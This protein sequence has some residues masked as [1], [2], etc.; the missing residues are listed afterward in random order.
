M[1][2]IEAIVGI[3]VAG[4]IGAIGGGTIGLSLMGQ[5]ILTS[6]IY[7]GT[8][9]SRS[10]ASK[11]ES[12]TNSPTYQFNTLQTQT[13]NQLPIP[14]I[15][16][17]NKIAGNR[18]WQQYRDNNT[19]IDRIVAFGEGPIEDIED[20]RLNDIPLSE[21]QGVDFRLYYGTN[22]Q[23]T[24]P[25][26]GSSLNDRISTV[27]SLKNIAY[28][29]LSVKA[30][31]KIRGDYNLTTVVK[32][33]KVRVYSSENSYETK[34]SNNP[35][36][37]LLDFL[38][39]YNGCGIGLSATGARDDYKIKEFIDINSFI[40]AANICDETVEDA[41]RFCFN[42]IIDSQSQRQEILEEFKK[43]CR[44]A[45]TIKGKRL[46]L[47]ID[48]NSAPCKT[49]FAKDII[50]GTEQ[51]STLPKDENY[52]RIVVKYR[53]KAQEWSICEAIA[54]K[55]TFDNI[56]PI[57][58]T[59]SI[60]GVTDHNQ[61]SRLAWYYL[62]KVAKERYFGYF[63]TDYRAFGLEIGDVIN[64]N[65]NLME[66]VDKAVKVTKLIDKNDG[67]FGVY[68][69]EN[70]PSIYSDTKG[71]IE[72]TMALCAIQNDYLTPAN[73]EGFCATQILNTINLSWTRLYGGD[74]TYE[75][76]SGENWDT[77][78]ILCS[79]FASNSILLPVTSIGL[80]KFFIKAKSKYNFYSTNASVAIA[81]V[82]SIPSI[83]TIVKNEIFATK[84]GQ[85]T[86]VKIYNNTVKPLP[87]GTWAKQM[88]KNL[89]I[90]YSD[91]KNK[92]GQIV[93]AQAFSYITPIFD[94]KEIFTSLISLNY[95]FMAQNT[96]Q[97]ISIQIRFSSDGAIWL[98]WQ[99]F[100]EGSFEFRFYQ[101]KIT[102]ENPQKHSFCL[103]N[104][105]LSV[106]VPDR[107][108]HYNNI[109]V[110]DPN[111]GVVIDFA[112]HAQSK[113][114]KD[115]LCIPSI[116]ANITGSQVG[117]CVITQKSPKSF[118]IKTFSDTNTPITATCD[119]HAK[120]Y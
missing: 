67:T 70:D 9:L 107:D 62:N 55:E 61:A 85:K 78:K 1:G 65:D 103:N 111:N 40:E 66:F 106:D 113:I 35:A 8:A 115:F 14:S 112:T 72:P 92:W 63:E 95:D 99:T 91:L 88:P 114:N 17:E 7:G 37:C 46:Q 16:G 71:S 77:G 13:N 69:R 52:D 87:S 89:Q 68:W 120:G 28:V 4:S 118:T 12:H 23:I 81:Y 117:Y 84:N 41:P 32:G 51:F 29:A 48:T 38:T 49:I 60:Y 119:I 116:V 53:S 83:N 21:L 98:P 57:E 27:G 3:V 43:T 100:S 20:I 74:I 11:K 94:L 44:G 47:K 105:V 19:V 22:T 56:P 15:Y 86:G 82:E 110:T 10:L 18:L 6:V 101:L 42:M 59:V 36:W 45:L 34:Y 80:K 96:S 50:A 102:G 58:H 24:D 25:I 109:S 75:I 64:L 97:S 5:A 76:R 31:E 90:P 26:V 2:I 39:A 54:E 33:R 79:N 104:T 30:T 73:I 93:E 108:E